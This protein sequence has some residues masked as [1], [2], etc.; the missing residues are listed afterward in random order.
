MKTTLFAFLIVVSCFTTVLLSQ[1]ITEEN[2]LRSDKELWDK[3]EQ[4][5]NKI[6]DLKRNNPDKKDSLNQVLNQMFEVVNQQNCDTAIK[7]AS[8]PSG[9]KR[10][11][12]VRLS[13]SKDTLRSIFKTLPKE[14]Q[15]SDYGKNLLFHIDSKQIEEGDPYFDFEATDT[16]GNNFRLSSVKSNTILLVYDGLSCMGESGR[17]LLKN[18]HEK[19]QRDSFQI[20]VYSKSTNM[21]QLKELQNKYQIKYL[22][23][24][25]FLGDSS[26]MKI[27]YGV[28]AVPTCFLIDKARNVVMKSM[29]L[30]EETLNKMLEEKKL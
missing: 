28:Q 14:M 10:L 1:E 7:Y 23:V 4:E 3:Y 27:I 5:C 19:T 29:G 17:G 2:Y 12:M 9:L 26:P 22:L 6:L 16:S 18:L 25:D 13:L 30:P 15:E 21:I 11:F 20:V 8:V 24:S